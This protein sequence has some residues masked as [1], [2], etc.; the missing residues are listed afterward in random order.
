[1]AA[2]ALD[3]C[4][5]RIQQIIHGHRRVASDPLYRARRTLH[6]GI[7]LLTDRQGHRLEQ[8]FADDDH[9]QVE[10]TWVSDQRRI[11]GYHELDRVHGRELMTK[12]IDGLN[13]GLPQP[14]TELHTH[15][16]TLK[17]RAIDVLA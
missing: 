4:R 17:K 15:G 12:V 5:R 8:L 7:D 9:V 3:R 16:R 13:H 1:M 2:D 10:V 11:P 6:S 14:L